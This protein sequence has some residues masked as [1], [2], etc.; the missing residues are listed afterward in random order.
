MTT[1]VLSFRDV[2]GME[3]QQQ[4]QLIRSYK[5]G[6]YKKIYRELSYFYRWREIFDRLQFGISFF[7][8][9]K[10][11]FICCHFSSSSSATSPTNFD[12]PS[13]KIMRDL[14]DTLLIL[15][16]LQT[17]ERECYWRGGHN[18]QN[19]IDIISLIRWRRKRRRW[20]DTHPNA[21]ECLLVE[22]RESP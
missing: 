8:I 22:L 1:Q 20:R 3:L 12:I 15:Y 10:L 9:M 14:R 11:L 16:Y 18:N 5:R 6:K 2:H 17:K 4:S 13:L 21:V 7:S 19:H